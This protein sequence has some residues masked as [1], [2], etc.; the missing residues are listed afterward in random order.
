MIRDREQPDKVLQL[1]PH[2]IAKERDLYV[3]P[4]PEDGALT[5]E[6]EKFFA[7]H[8]EGPFIPVRNHLAFGRSVGL[9]NQL[10]DSEDEALAYFL[11][12]QQVRT[13]AFREKSQL[14]EQWAGAM[15]AHTLFS[16]PEEVDRVHREMK[17]E[18]APPGHAQ[19]F[20][21]A[22]EK[23][24][25]V[26]EPAEKA[27]LGTAMRQVPELM[28]IVRSLPRRVIYAPAGIQFPTSDSPLVLVRRRS[29]TEFIHGGG[30]KEPHVEATIALS[31]QAVLVIGNTLESFDDHDS[32]EW[33]RQVR[34]RIVTGAHRWIYAPSDD[35]Q[36][37]EWL[38]SSKA[39][40]VVIEYPGGVFRHGDS[41]MAAIRDMTKRNPGE[42]IIRYGPADQ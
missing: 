21:N 11:A 12:F 40:E 7:T 41:A 2:A 19:F 26:V 23:E 20:L 22:L 8:I 27:W 18:P 36:L 33:A 29:R 16:D 28:P 38:Y 35:P 31:P 4:H 5:D 9:T 37:A 34:K 17:G 30:W 25:L 13:P 42:A 1:P 14:L 39:P 6:I 24:E 10:S 32:P 3:V 15:L